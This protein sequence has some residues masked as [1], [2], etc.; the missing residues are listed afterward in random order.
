MCT[1]IQLM[2]N[3]YIVHNCIQYIHI[4]TTILIIHYSYTYPLYILFFRSVAAVYTVLPQQPPA[5]RHTHAGA[6]AER[7]KAGMQCI[8]YVC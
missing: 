5:S 7:R 4:Y 8:V 1:T 2:L 6:A 3:K